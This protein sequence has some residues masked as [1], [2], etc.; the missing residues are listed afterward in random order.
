A[1][2][3]YARPGVE[4]ACLEAQQAGADV[5]LLLCGAWLDDLGRPYQRAASVCL[6]RLAEEQQ[7]ALIQP[8]RTARQQLRPA[9]QRAAQIARLREQIKELELAAER[10]LLEQLQTLCEQTLCEQP[11]GDTL[12]QRDRSRAPIWLAALAEPLAAGHPA[13]TLINAQRLALAA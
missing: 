5:C 9:A 8:L 7:A 6:R 10:R 13:L 11:P 2:A 4:D 12:W 3:L 1:L